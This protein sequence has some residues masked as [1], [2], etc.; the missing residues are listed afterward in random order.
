VLCI[1]AR[2]LFFFLS[3]QALIPSDSLQAT[4][5]L[6]ESAQGHGTEVQIPDPVVRLLEAY[7]LADEGFADEQAAALPLDL[8]ICANPPSLI[9]A[10]ILQLVQ[11]LRVLSSRRCVELRRRP[12]AQRLMGALLVEIRL[13][14]VEAPL[15]SPQVPGGRTSRVRLQGSMHPL[16]TPVLLRVT[17]LDQKRLDPELDPPHRQTRK[18]PESPRTERAPV[19]G[20]DRFRKSILAKHTLQDTLSAHG[21]GRVQAVATQ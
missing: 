1:G 6:L 4:I 12:L 16:V 18:A 21:R 10:G 9:V 5:P 14:S 3:P 19:V 7:P 2:C 13:E 8:A 20:E 15:L 11:M 17:R